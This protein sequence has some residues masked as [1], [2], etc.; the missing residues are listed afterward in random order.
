MSRSLDNKNR[1]SI[2][3]D[4][5]TTSISAVV[6]TRNEEA[7]IVAC[8]R[9]VAWCD[10]RIVIDDESADQTVELARQEDARVFRRAL[11]GDFAAQRNF[12]LQQASSDWVLF[13]DADE[14]VPSDLADEVRQAITKADVLGF[15][16]ARQD[17]FL[18]KPLRF[19]ETSNS[20]FLRLAR[21]GSGQWARPVHELWE[22]RGRVETLKGKIRH[23]PH[24]TISE[25]LKEINHYTDIEAGS[26]RAKGERAGIVSLIGYPTA[27]FIN[28]YLALLGFLDGFPGFVMAFMMSLHSLCVRVKLMS[29]R[30]DEA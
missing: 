3:N 15:R 26:R 25:F 17:L 30:K 14:R 28:N 24:P 5:E 9:S 16:V 1:F 21:K 4:S 6:L 20:R 7:N 27:K 18:G 22:V 23:H 19:G 8:L 2:R 11:R 12:G 10:E 29:T 13:L